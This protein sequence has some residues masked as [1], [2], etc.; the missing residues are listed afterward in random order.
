MADNAKRDWILI[1]PQAA[2]SE[3]AGGGGGGGER[4]RGAL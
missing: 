3:R 2:G 4:E 1:K